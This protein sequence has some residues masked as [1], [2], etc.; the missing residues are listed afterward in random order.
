MVNRQSCLALLAFIT[1]MITSCFGPTTPPLQDGDDQGPGDP[2]PP[3][4]FQTAS[5][6]HELLFDDP[7]QLGKNSAVGAPA[8][9]NVFPGSGPTPT[10][11]RLESSNR[12]A[13]VDSQPLLLPDSARNHPSAAGMTISVWARLDN[14]QGTAAE[15]LISTVVTNSPS[16]SGWQ[17]LYRPADDSYV[18]RMGGVP[19][20]QEFLLNVPEP[21]VGRWHHVA[22]VWDQDAGTLTLTANGLYTQTS[23]IDPSFAYVPSTTDLRI[24]INGNVSYEMS[25]QL[26]QLRVY[27]EPLPLE[28]AGAD[29]DVARLREEGKRIYYASG[30]TGLSSIYSATLAGNDVQLVATPSLTG[31]DS[32]RDIEVRADLGYVYWSN[33]T[34]RRLERAPLSG[35]SVETVFD[36]SA[37][38]EYPVAIPLIIGFALNGDGTV[39]YAGDQ[40]YDGILRVEIPTGEVTS[41]YDPAVG[42]SNLTILDVDLDEQNNRLYFL[43]EETIGPNSYALMRVGTDG[44][45]VVNLLENDETTTEPQPSALT[46]DIANNRLFFV[47]RLGTTYEMGGLS[48]TPAVSV[49][50]ATAGAYGD[51]VAFSH[52]DDELYLPRETTPGDLQSVRVSSGVVTNHNTVAADHALDLLVPRR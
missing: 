10:A 47:G 17:L 36:F 39:I 35:G 37:S 42:S 1:L 44:T 25:G 19:D 26:D 21:V 29:M 41:V 9:S 52:V 18:F 48:G 51:S 5:L 40:N 43:E 3:T 27:S 31:A 23:D 11:D 50:G 16:G 49:V 45:N 4:E 12:A 33:I 46:L 38:A 8:A 28:D 15:M 24:G 30:S 20:D 34:S 14:I 13:A 7:V 22:V 32:L 2:P 6:V